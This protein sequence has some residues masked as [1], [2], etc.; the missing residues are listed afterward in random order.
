MIGHLAVGV[1]APVEALADRSQHRQPVEPV[2]IVPED[3]LPAVATGGYVVEP[4]R[5]LDAEWS[6][7]A[8]KRRRKMLDYKT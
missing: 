6:R 3:F 8:L 1:A 4:A 7:H 5:E 2:F